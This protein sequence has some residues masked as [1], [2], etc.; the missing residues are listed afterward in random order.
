MGNIHYG[1]ITAQDAMGALNRCARYAGFGFCVAWGF[2]LFAV[3]EF[4]PSSGLNIF[5]WSMAPGCLACLFVIAISRW[6]AIS[7]TRSGVAFCC[8]AL[9][10]VGTFLHASP[11]ASNQ[12][13]NMLVSYWLALRLLGCFCRGLS[14]TLNYPLVKSSCLRGWLWLSDP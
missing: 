6:R 1:K 3:P 5:L 7:P 8:A 11:I 4:Q 14:H 10:S 13:F 9:A 2:L 12:A